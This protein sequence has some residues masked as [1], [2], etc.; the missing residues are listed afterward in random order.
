MKL[1][2]Y[3]HVTKARRTALPRASRPGGGSR[4]GAAGFNGLLAKLSGAGDQL[5]AA[6][7]RVRRP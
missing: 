3:P 7:K 4:P 6:R 1:T 5:A 2:L